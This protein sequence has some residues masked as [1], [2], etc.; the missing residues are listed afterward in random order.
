MTAGA[1]AD[2]RPL[3]DLGRLALELGLDALRLGTPLQP[4]ALLQRD[5]ADIEVSWQADA[6]LAT[7]F[8][9]ARHVAATSGCSRYAI[10]THEDILDREGVKR[11]AIVAEAGDREHDTA[12]RMAQ[13]YRPYLA[14]TQRAE[15]IGTPIMLGDTANVLR[16]P[17]P[18]PGPEPAFVVLCPSCSRKNRVSLRRVREQLPKC[19]AC[20]KPLLG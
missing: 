6:D 10:A 13:P 4:F 5:T 17:P 14:P 16:T 20:R 19:G 11:A 18:T 9:R 1:T 15:A 2:P 7:A 8:A 3:R 12:L